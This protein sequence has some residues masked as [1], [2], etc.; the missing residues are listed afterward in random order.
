MRVFDETES[1]LTNS[2]IGWVGLGGAKVWM[3]MRD[4]D[5]GTKSISGCFDATLVLCELE[6]T[7][8]GS[9]RCSRCYNILFEHV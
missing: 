4:S 9:L 1:G 7:S 2:G 8:V 6:A 3:P 5:A